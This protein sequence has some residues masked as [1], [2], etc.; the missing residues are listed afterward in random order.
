[1]TKKRLTQKDIGRAIGISDMTVSRV[2]TGRGTVSEGT[3][4]KV[5]KAVHELGYLKNR[6]AG[7]FSKNHSNQIGVVLPTLQVGI[8][9][10][11]L[12][13]IT[14]ELEKA[15]YNPIV[16]ITGYDVE[17]EE[18]LVESMLSWN[19]AGMIVND[20]VHTER[21]RQLL[22]LED[23]PVVE[24]MAFSGEPIDICVGFD[25]AQAA[26][27]LVDHLISKG[28]R[29][30]AFLGWHGTGFSA[31]AR[32]RAI[33]HRLE[34]HGLPLVAPVWYSAPPG[35]EDGKIGLARLVESGADMDVI[36]LGNDMMAAGALI[37]CQM[38][39]WPVPERFALA[40]FGGLAIGQAMA[41]T[42]TTIRFPRFEVGKR[43]ARTVLNAMVGQQVER[44]SDL[45]FE[46]LEGETC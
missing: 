6:M 42:I 24:I 19:A 1:M 7:S 21:T 11:V 12:Q 8:F 16:G 45:G 14:S 13:G 4:R 18:S 28:Y 37:Q 30:F 25:H 22:G 9:P 41:Q 10:E 17:R 29:K 2:L 36:L 44:I 39:G 46:L 26:I 20:F 40:G 3:R 34:T 35:I 38:S 15:G 5:L 23:V 32:F 31:S 27:C 33:K 43:A